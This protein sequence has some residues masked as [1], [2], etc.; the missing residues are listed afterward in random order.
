MTIKIPTTNEQN[1]SHAP[2]LKRRNRLINNHVK[3]E[4]ERSQ[5]NYILNIILNTKYLI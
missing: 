3:Y 1:S 5:E 4:I 2:A